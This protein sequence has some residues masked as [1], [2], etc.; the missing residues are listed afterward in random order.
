[1]P[2]WRHGARKWLWIKGCHFQNQQRTIRRSQYNSKFEHLKPKYQVLFKILIGCV[3]PNGGLVDHVNISRWIKTNLPLI[4]LE[5]LRSHASTLEHWKWILSLIQA[6]EEV[7]ALFKRNTWYH[8]LPHPIS[9]TLSRWDWCP[10]STIFD[11]MVT[12]EEQWVK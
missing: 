4:I 6:L 7:E 8:L 3:V 12:L 10:P 5:H 9:R 11:P 1:M 2:K